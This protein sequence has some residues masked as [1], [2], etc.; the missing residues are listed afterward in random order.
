VA[1]PAL[2][3]AKLTRDERLE[4]LE[5]LWDSLSRESEP[6]P[7]TEEQEAELDRRLDALDREGAVGIS[8]EELRERIR[9]R[10]S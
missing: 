10:P 6:L 2:D 7:L 4:L 8:P 9:N 3:L 5:E 1:K